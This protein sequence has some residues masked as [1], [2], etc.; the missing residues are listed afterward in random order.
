MLTERVGAVEGGG[1]KGARWRRSAG[2]SDQRAGLDKREG[3]KAQAYSRDEGID[4]LH[5]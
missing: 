5:V 3:C 2:A 1:G 4:E